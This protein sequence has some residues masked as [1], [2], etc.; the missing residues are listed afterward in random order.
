MLPPLWC[1]II[2][3]REY[4][5]EWSRIHNYN[6][7]GWKCGCGT[8]VGGQ[9]KID[10]AEPVRYPILQMRKLKGAVRICFSFVVAE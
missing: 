6:L 3:F 9:I 4:E 5:L 1:K 8:V 10:N 2:T 7:D